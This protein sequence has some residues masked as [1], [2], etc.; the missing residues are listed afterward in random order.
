MY[1]ESDP[2]DGDLDVGIAAYDSADVEVHDLEVTQE[3]E[4]PVK[5][6]PNLML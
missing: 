1:A 6:V 2:F 3:G 4:Q 5:K